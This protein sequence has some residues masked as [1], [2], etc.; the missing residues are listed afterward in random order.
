MISSPSSCTTFDKQHRLHGFR[1]AVVL[2]KDS[3]VLKTINPE[4]IY[5]RHENRDACVWKCPR[6]I[7]SN[8]RSWTR[9]AVQAQSLPGAKTLRFDPRKINFA[10]EKVRGVQA[11]TTERGIAP[12]EPGS[13]RRPLLTFEIQSLVFVVE[14]IICEDMWWK[15]RRACPPC[16]L[17]TSRAQSENR[18]P[19]PSR[20]YFR[21]LTE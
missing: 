5:S 6:T 20:S 8:C 14:Q 19:R 7:T 10:P 18:L 11:L 21:R 13:I 1:S 3:S 17:G 2:C 15:P 9:R 16:L 12:L 4:E